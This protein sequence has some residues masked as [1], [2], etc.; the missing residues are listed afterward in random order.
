MNKTCKIYL[1]V[2]TILIFLFSTCSSI[3]YTSKNQKDLH[4]KLSQ[5]K[6]KVAVLPFTLNLKADDDQAAFNDIDIE[7]TNKFTEIIWKKN[8]VRIAHNKE[9][10]DAIQGVD[11]KYHELNPDMKDLKFKPNL[12]KIIALGKELEANVVF[13]GTIRENKF[14]FKGGCCCLMPRLFANKR[15]YKIGAQM[16]AVD[17][18]RGKAFAFDFIDND[19]QVKTRFSSLTGGVSDEALE[20]GKTRLLEKC[21]LAL[22]YYA[23]MPEERTNAGIVAIQTGASLLNFFTDSEFSVDFSIRDETWK[24]Y[25]RGYFDE[26]FGY[27][28]ENFNAIQNE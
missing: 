19:I 15:V 11:L 2:F 13:T 17:V 18:D 22:A 7:L 4:E 12:K 5:K 1:L 27:T 24:M 3:R 26:N 8:K 21:G 25:P 23:P 9:V 28:R 20:E 16:M 14:D 6:M 10:M